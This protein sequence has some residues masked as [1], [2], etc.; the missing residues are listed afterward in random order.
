MSLLKDGRQYLNHNEKD[1]EIV[2][3]GYRNIQHKWGFTLKDST[4]PI[5]SQD[6]I[7]FLG[8]EMSVTFT[9]R[10]GDSLVF[11]EAWVI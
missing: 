11:M 9:E 1:Y 7:I 5:F 4:A 8:A 10:K 2:T 6:K 3:A